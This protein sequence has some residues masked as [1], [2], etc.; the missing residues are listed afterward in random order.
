MLSKKTVQSFSFIFWVIFYVGVNILDKFM[1]ASKHVV[2]DVNFKFIITDEYID[3]E[4]VRWVAQRPR[5]NISLMN[6]YQCTW[7]PRNNHFLRY[8]DVKPKGKFLQMF[9]SSLKL[10]LNELFS[11]FIGLQKYQTQNVFQAILSDFDFWTFPT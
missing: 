8:Q 1:D 3:E 6:H 10:S 9:K 11:S 4:G 2:D 7:K 5:P